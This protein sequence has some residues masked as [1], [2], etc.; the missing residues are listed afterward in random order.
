MNVPCFR[1]LRNPFGDVFFR[2]EFLPCFGTFHCPNPF[3]R[4]KGT[5]SHDRRPSARRDTPPVNRRS[6]RPESNLRGD[7][8]IA[9]LEDSPPSMMFGNQKRNNSSVSGH[10][11]TE[12]TKQKQKT[13]Q[14]LGCLKKRKRRKQLRPS[15]H[16]DGADSRI[17]EK[18]QKTACFLR[19]RAR[20]FAGR[21]LIL[22]NKSH[23]FCFPPP[24]TL[25]RR[26]CL[27]SVTI[28]I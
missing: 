21:D 24:P 9:A 5:S 17:L 20:L 2:K 28:R 7:R 11:F 10:I 16:R 19:Y 22:T 6:E 18:Q 15:I 26:D 27:K 12:T 14:H 25:H 8:E 3:W 1:Y 4:T 23:Q 13:H